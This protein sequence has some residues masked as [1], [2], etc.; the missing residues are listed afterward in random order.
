MIENDRHLAVEIA[1]EQI[2][3]LLQHPAGVLRHLEQARD[4]HGFE[5]PDESGPAHQVVVGLLHPG[6]AAR[7]AAAMMGS[8]FRSA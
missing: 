8:R 5:V 2:D 4:I 1:V 3:H 7:H 6:L